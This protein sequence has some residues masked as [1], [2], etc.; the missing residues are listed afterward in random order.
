MFEI[1]KSEYGKEL[2]MFEFDYLG[3][4]QSLDVILINAKVKFYD[5]G[6]HISTGLSSDSLFAEWDCIKGATCTKNAQ[7]LINLKTAEGVIKLK[8]EK[9]DTDIGEFKKL[10]K[11]LVP[12]IAIDKLLC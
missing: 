1:I 12:E 4:H 11:L 7:A 10:L 8:K 2:G 3:A 9:K 6:L 5:K